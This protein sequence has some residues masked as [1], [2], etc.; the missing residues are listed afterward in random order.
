MAQVL[1]FL[2]NAK[3]EMSE[4]K[5]AFVTTSEQVTELYTMRDDVQLVRDLGV[6]Q[7]QRVKSVQTTLD[8]ILESA[9]EH[10]KAIDDLVEKLN[11]LEATFDDKII[12]SRD[13]VLLNFQFKTA[14]IEAEI[15]N[16]RD[17]LNI[18]QEH[19]G[20]PSLESNS[21]GKT[22]SIGRPNPR[23]ITSTNPS[24]QERQI[25]SG[26]GPARKNALDAQSQSQIEIL[27]DMCINFEGVSLRKTKVEDIPDTICEQMALI[28]QAVS[29][30]I[31]TETDKEALQVVIRGSSNEDV[32]P[33][34]LSEKSQR[35]V[36]E[37]V[38]SVKCQIEK[39]GGQ[40]G[41]IRM[42]AR[43]KFIFQLHKAMQTGMSKHDQVLVVGNSRFGRLKIPSC[44]A[45]DRPLLNK[46]R[47]AD[48]S[49]AIIIPRSDMGNVKP[50]NL[51]R[52]PIDQHDE[53]L[54]QESST[55]SMKSITG[56]KLEKSVRMPS[57]SITKSQKMSTSQPNLMMRSG[58]KVP[59]SSN[60]AP[61]DEETSLGSSSLPEL[62][63]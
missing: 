26:T 31:A 27:G 60:A 18:I 3:N 41:I 37:F 35:K 62:N 22:A 33:E 19:V 7:E 51:M 6:A 38:A 39:G 13:G 20:E 21:D 2:D 17:N 45:C 30:T 32:S 54:L 36:D 29:E 11:K 43:E 55:G 12:E 42:E 24:E 49:N 52:A 61:M 48:S 23:S 28:A 25:K 59:K 15:Q 1:G 40:P 56:S 53:L 57:L 44:I 58:L 34:S 8:S 4:M 9:D 10:D 63:P 50:M 16:L 46:V 47:Q 14:E 5:T